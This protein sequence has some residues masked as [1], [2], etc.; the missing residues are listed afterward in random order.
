MPL[1]TRE[2]T[3]FAPAKVNLH[4]AVKDKRADGFHNIESVFI[5]VDF[6]DF[7]HFQ[8]GTGEWNEAC[9]LEADVSN[10]NSGIIPMKENIIYKAVSVFRGETGFSQKIK[11]KLEKNIPIG[12]GLGGGSSD[13]A[14]VLLALNETAGFPCSLKD[15]LKMGEA[16]GSDVPFFIHQTSAAIVTGRGEIIKAI[17]I[18]QMYLVIVNPGFQ[19][20]SSC[21]YKLLDEYRKSKNIINESESMNVDFINHFDIIN[22]SSFL[23]SFLPVF[24]EPEKS[25]YIDIIS[26]LN[27]AGAEFAGLSGSGSTCFG[28]FSDWE[29]AQKVSDLLLKKCS[30]VKAVKTFRS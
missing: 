10:V 23:N 24:D 15:L 6:G 3:V 21:A 28:I 5:A 29:T 14:A 7:L 27:A 22:K 13:A 17:K 11:I 1:N 18:P 8:I 20:N 30:F 16:L 9:I 4:L 2:F 26:Q 19:S 25:I 12:G